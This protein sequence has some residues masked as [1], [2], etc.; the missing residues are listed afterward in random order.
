MYLLYQRHS[1]V[2]ILEINYYNSDDDTI[3]FQNII[4][5]EKTKVKRIRTLNREKRLH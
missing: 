4:A 1:T 5:T 3:S 2:N